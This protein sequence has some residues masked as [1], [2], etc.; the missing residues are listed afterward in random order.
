GED[1]EIRYASRHAP[2]KSMGDTGSELSLIF[3]ADQPFNDWLTQCRNNHVKCEKVWR[4]VADRLAGDPDRRIFDIVATY[5]KESPAPVVIMAFDRSSEY[6]PEDDQL[7]FISFAAHELRGPVTVIRGYLDVFREEMENPGFDA[8]ERNAL[9]SR[10]IVSS[11]RLSG[12]ITNILNT[13]RYDRRHLKMN[14]REHTL[15]QVY[16][17]IADDMSLRAKTQNRLLTVQLSSNLPTVAVDPSSL[18]EV[19]SN[20]ID[21]ALKYSHEGGTVSV[22]A[23]VDRDFVVVSVIDQG[24]GMPN[25][26]ISNL[27]HKFYRSHRSRETVSGTGIGLYISK[28]IVEAHGGIIEAKSVEGRGSTFSFSVPVYASVADKLAKNANTNEGIIRKGNEGWI[29]N[30]AKIRG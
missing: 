3:D 12:Y 11:N 13:S 22:T 25:T 26:V 8:R 29:K 24:I 30:H 28:A 7:D 2:V 15:A 20:L 16:A 18:S 27:F 1:G 17:L 4:R 6:Q 14:L 10:L 19:F 21:N 23:A 9:L 5:E